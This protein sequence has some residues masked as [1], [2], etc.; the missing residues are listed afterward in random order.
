METSVVE[1]FLLGF[2]GTSLPE[3]LS[4]LLA[5]GLAGVTIFHRN[6]TSPEGLR[7]LTREIRRA[8]SRPVLISIDQEGG[9][10]FA[11]P[12]PFTIWPTPAELGL[13]GDAAVVE[14]MARAMA[15]ELRAA[16]C[17]LN[18]APM[19][20]LAMNP[21]SPVTTERSLGADPRKVARLGAAFIRGL[22]GGGVLACA[23]HYPGHG[24]TQ[25]DPHVDLPVFHGTIDRLKHVELVPFA[26]AIS[27]SVPVIMTAHILLSQI[28]PER[29]ASLSRVMLSK[30]LRQ[31]MGFRGVILA[32]DLGMGAIA[33]RLGP[34]DAAVETF[35]AGSDLALLCHDWSA[36]RPALEATQKALDHGLIHEAK[37]QASHRRIESLRAEAEAGADEVPGLDVVGC[38]EH[39]ALAEE[40]RARIAQARER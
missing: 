35:L 38:A 1:R 21:A 26:E 32:D 39:R 9:T 20:D 13:V 24:D 37:Q 30:I 19:L 25:V 18:F 14:Q 2:E 22:Q 40:I 10:R 4:A 17:N 12:E 33:Q 36:V 3:E 23:K 8:A 7:L 6:F 5:Q 28:D 15:R 29:P 11:L 31:Q 16:G 27:S 34:G